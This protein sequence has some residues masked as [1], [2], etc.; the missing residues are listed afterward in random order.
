MN[1]PGF[2]DKD[3]A[4][5]EALGYRITGTAPINSGA[6]VQVFRAT[7]KGEP[8]AAKVLNLTLLGKVLGEEE[9]KDYRLKSLPRELCTL[10]K[11]KHPHLVAI[12]DVYSLGSLS[13]VV[14]FLELADG[15][16]LLDL[17]KDKGTWLSEFRSRSLFM[18]FGDALRYLHS[19]DTATAHRDVKCEN[20]LLNQD[21]TA[22]KLT[23]FGFSRSVLDAITSRRGVP[24]GGSGTYC[25]SQAYS[26]PEVIKGTTP[27]DPKKADVWSTGVVLFVLLNNKFPF[28][29]TESFE[30][31][32]RQTEGTY[33]YRNKTL[34][35]A[36]RQ[37]ISL[38]FTVSPADR[39]SMSE[40]FTHP[41]FVIRPNVGIKASPST[42]PLPSMTSS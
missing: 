6:F 30:M 34:T 4:S 36:V 42:T 10:R 27:C 24:D 5:L 29:D 33:S 41:W 25:G 40:L 2:P 39:P 21:R 17:L 12:H 15:G 13:W 8:C 11:L 7:R 38:L 26:P 3:R 31:L 22:C 14:L 23:D 9:Q 32:K 37:V 16:D 28:S 19:I 35:P 1:D 18:Q 20:V